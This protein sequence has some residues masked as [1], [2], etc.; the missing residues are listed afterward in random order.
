MAIRLRIENGVAWMVGA[1]VVTAED[2]SRALLSLVSDAALGPKPR[3]LCDLRLVTRLELDTPSVRELVE[4]TAARHDRLSGA[5]IAVAA[6][7]DHVYG[8]VRMYQTMVFELPIELGLHRDLEGARA[9][10]DAS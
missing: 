5:R 8:V 10:L 1:G 7:A 9:W 4:L 6:P 2:A 3:I